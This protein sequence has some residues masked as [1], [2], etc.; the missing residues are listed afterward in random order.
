[1]ADKQA[2]TKQESPDLLDY[3]ADPRRCPLENGSTTKRAS[4]LSPLDRLAA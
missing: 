3:P 1:M 4:G 2:I